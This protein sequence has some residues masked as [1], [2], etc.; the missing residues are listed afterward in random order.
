MDP[1]D[2]CRRWCKREK[3]Y[4]AVKR[5]A[6]VRQYNSKMGRVDLCDRMLAFYRIKTRTKKWTVRTIM[7]F[8]DLALVN[9]WILYQRDA[10]V[11]KI[12]RKDVHQFLAFKLDV[13]KGVYSSSW[14]SP[15]NY[16]TPLVNGITQC[17]LPPDRGDRPAFTLTGQVGTRF[18]DPVRMKGWVGLVCWLHTE[19]VYPSTDGHPSEYWRSATTLIEANALPL[20][21]TASTC[22]TNVLSSNWW[23][24]SPQQWRH[25]WRGTFTPNQTASYSGNSCRPTTY[26]S[27]KTS[28]RNDRN[29]KFN[30]L[31][32]AWLQR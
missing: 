25:I 30:A 10:K 9:S 14:N 4:V 31:Q 26:C 8:I 6:I 7:H 22:G 17:Y 2:E 12:P 1:E 23:W 16:G 28:T 15:Q 19:M 11:L 24:S 5:P 21:Q 27:C 18:I 3:K 20:S 13:K 29:E 32:N